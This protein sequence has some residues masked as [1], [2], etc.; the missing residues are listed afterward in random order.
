MGQRGL[1]EVLSSNF[2]PRYKCSK[3]VGTIN[4]VR[5]LNRHSLH[6]FR[7]S[8]SGNIRVTSSFPLSMLAEIMLTKHSLKRCEANP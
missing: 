6:C 5:G 7:Q 2:R 4:F 8:C 1:L 3:V